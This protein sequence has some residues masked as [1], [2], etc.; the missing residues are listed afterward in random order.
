M[1]VVTCIRKEYA[2][3]VY[4][5]RER[6]SRVDTTGIECV[7]LWGDAIERDFIGNAM[8]RKSCDCII[9]SEWKEDVI[10]LFVELKRGTVKADD[11]IVKMQTCYEHATN[12]LQ[13][14]SIRPTGWNP[15][16]LVVHR[17]MKTHEM[18]QLRS[19]RMRCGGKR[20]P[21]WSR[22]SPLKLRELVE[23]W[24]QFVQ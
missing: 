16:F 3:Y 19:K 22:P 12:I 9:I 10:V 6:G 13:H 24:H 4:R 18:A 1:S 5:C 23:R 21:I 14:C 15:I 2:N 8:L 7:V 20:Y 11:C 17:R